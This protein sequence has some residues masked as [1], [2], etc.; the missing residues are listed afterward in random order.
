MNEGRTAREPAAHGNDETNG[1]PD[2]RSQPCHDRNHWAARRK[3]LQRFGP[4]AEGPGRP[5]GC[6][7]LDHSAD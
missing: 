2:A 4:V 6:R 5:G 3:C 7:P 1:K